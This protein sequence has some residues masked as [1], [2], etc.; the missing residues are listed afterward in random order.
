[1]QYSSKP[2]L[3]CNM[4]FASVTTLAVTAILSLTGGVLGAPAK[5][6]TGPIT[7]PFYITIVPADGSAPYPGDVQTVSRGT[8]ILSSA[9]SYHHQFNFDLTTK[10]LTPSH[11]PGKPNWNI[12]PGQTLVFGLEGGNKLEQVIKNCAIYLVKE[13][14]AADG[15]NVWWSVPSPG[16]AVGVEWQGKGSDRANAALRIST[17]PL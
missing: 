1:M 9:L 13:G 14:T 6:P 2:E 7:G 16:W 5:C 10:R 15:V 3:H 11:L 4:H 17:T 8:D 12:T